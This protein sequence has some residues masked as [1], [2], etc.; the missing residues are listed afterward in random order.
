MKEMIRVKKLKIEDLNGPD[1]YGSS[2]NRAVAH[3]AKHLHTPAGLRFVPSVDGLISSGQVLNEPWV[4]V[5]HGVPN[6]SDE[7]SSLNDLRNFLTLNNNSMSC[8]G[9]WVL[10]DQAKER[11]DRW[12]L[13]IPVARLHSCKLDR[14][15]PQ[16]TNSVIYR[17]LPT[18]NTQN[19]EFGKFGLTV[20]II[21]YKRLDNIGRILES[22]CHQN[23]SDTF[24]IIVWNNNAA[25][26]EALDEIIAPFR[27][28][29]ELTVLHSSRNY[30]CIVRLAVVHLMRS[31]L[32]M[33]CDD[34]VQPTADYLSTFVDGL[35]T[36]GPRSVV[37][38]RGNTFRPHRL[39]W[40][41]PQRVWEC[42]EHLDFYDADAPPCELHFMHGSSCLIP[43]EALLELAR[44]DLP[45]RDFILV[46]DYWISF[47]L[48][49]RLG[50]RIWKIR[51]DSAFRFDKSA[52]DPSVALFL[53]E[54]VREER[55]NFYIYHMTEG[56]PRGCGV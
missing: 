55:T 5:W 26:S 4:G 17:N 35:S 44:L 39:N 2:W 33:I 40:D 37:C 8:L 27:S 38:A 43:R 15:I 3:L 41:A 22:L 18:P 31:E 28:R 7:L 48:S 42:W 54:R 30:Y 13:S 14:F 45:R 36:A 12:K 9:L 20:L 21:S 34:D 52:E 1:F 53:N 56:W 24:E 29:L 25:A 47:A 23:Y 50:W 49:A 6:S 32:L 10:S 46:D 19:Y 16:L 51:A 11:I